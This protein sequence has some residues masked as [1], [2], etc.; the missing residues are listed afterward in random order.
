[1]LSW[2]R[3]SNAFS[4]TVSGLESA[5]EPSTFL[6]SNRWR[7]TGP[8]WSGSI[9]TACETRTNF[10]GDRIGCICLANPPIAAQQIERQQ[11]R[12]LRA[13]GQAA[14]FDPEDAPLAELP[15]KLGEEPRLADTGLA[16]DADHLAAAVFDLPHK[17]VQD[18]EFT[19]AVDKCRHPSRCRLAQPGA[20]MG[21]TEQ[22][23]CQDRLGLALERQAA[24]PV[25]REQNLA[26]KGGSPRSAGSFPA[27]PPAEVGRRHWPCRRSPCD[28]SAIG[29]RSNQRSPGRCE[30][31]CARASSVARQRPSHRRRRA[32]AEWR[33]RPTEH[34]ARGPR[35][36]AGAPKRAKNPSP[37]NCGAVPP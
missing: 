3:I 19:L 14:A 8:S 26:P 7:R 37:V 2:R 16:D 1:M 13:V 30:C 25:R 9:P 12:D 23:I 36:S 21:N 5:G 34:A 15:A 27:R 29:R 35:A 31:R 17:V 4:L 28:P 22:A 10:V 20:P 32:L 24:R 6:I 18:R 33:R 11:V